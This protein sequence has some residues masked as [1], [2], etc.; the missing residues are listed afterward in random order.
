MRSVVRASKE[1]SGVTKRLE[2]ING[3]VQQVAAKPE[4]LMSWKKCK[5][6]DFTCGGVAETVANQRRLHFGNE[7]HQLTLSNMSRPRRLCDPEFREATCRKCV[8]PRATTNFDAG[9][10]VSSCGGTKV[11]RHVEAV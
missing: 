5:H 11:K 6:Y 9:C 3:H 2:M 8:L 1:K 7:S 4:P 10:N